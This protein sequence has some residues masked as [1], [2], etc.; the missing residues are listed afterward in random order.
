LK[1]SAKA[2]NKEKIEKRS[3]REGGREVVQIN[4]EEN[5]SV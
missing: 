5:L 4:A 3:G 1:V 2:L